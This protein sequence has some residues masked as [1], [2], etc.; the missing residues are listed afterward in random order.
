MSSIINSNIN[1]LVAQANL[2]RS[3]SA[4]STSIQR[5]SSGLRINSSADDAAGYAIAQG[6]TSQ[7]NG[8][9]QAIRNASDGVSLAQVAGGAVNQITTDLQRIRQLAV[10]AANSTN[11]ATDRMDLQQEVSQ[12]VG[13]ISSIGNT[14]QFNGLNILDGSYSGQQYQVGPNVGNTIAVSI[15]DSRSQSL[16]ASALNSGSGVAVAGAGAASL[17]GSFFVNGVKVD[18]SLAA[19]QA[20]VV[21]A[22]NAQSGATGVTALRALTNVNTVAYAKDA[23]NNNVL[24]INGVSVNI[25]ANSTEATA[26]AA[27]NAVSAQTGVTAVGVAASGKLTLSSANAGDVK[28]SDDPG[29]GVLGAVNGGATVS[30]STVT[31]AAG[32]T[33]AAAVN[34]AVSVTEGSGSSAKDLQLLSSSGAPAVAATYQVSTVDVSTLAKANRAIETIDFALQQVA[35]V[36]A[37]L[38]AIQNRFTATIGNLQTASTNLTSSRST[39][40]DADFAAE[41]TSLTRSQVLQQAGTAI[42]AQA[43]Q[44]PSTVLKL[45]Q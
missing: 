24:N 39:I 40:Q 35:S 19:S 43:N 20:D 37:T 10:Q 45:L 41:T 5:L 6:F 23:V 3:Q 18:T 38:G 22:V 25:P 14:T 16:G 7:I 36:A 8:T 17:A 11:S 28:L 44:I 26:A 33:L 32:I 12:L 15:A 1:S 42:L 9:N 4:L 31:L 27:I 2:S 13:D 30:K 29:N 34:S 21:A